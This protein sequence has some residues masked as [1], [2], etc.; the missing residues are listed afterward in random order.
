MQSERSGQNAG[1]DC[2][3]GGGSFWTIRSSWNAAPVSEPAAQMTPDYGEGLL[4]PHLRRALRS[5]PV[6][7]LLTLCR[8]P[9]VL[10]GAQAG[11]HG[12]SLCGTNKGSINIGQMRA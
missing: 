10:T 7:A 12:I 3:G 9:G 6:T 11:M 5:T 4:A 2:R 1:G 8:S